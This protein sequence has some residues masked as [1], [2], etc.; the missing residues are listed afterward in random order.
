MKLTE[1]NEHR[2]RALFR[3]RDLLTAIILIAALLVTYNVWKNAIQIAN[4]ALQSNFAFRVKEVN[5]R[6]Q[7]RMAIY[8]QV[9]LATSGLFRAS[10]TVSREEFHI[11]IESLSIGKNYPG[12]QGV[13]FAAIVPPD[14]VDR[15]IDAVRKEGFPD[16]TISPE[17]PRDI[18]TAIVYLEPFAGRNLRAFGFD[19]YSDPTRRAAMT[20]ARDTGM[21]A[22]SGK[23]ILVQEGEQDIQFGF[24][25][26]QPIY[27][28]GTDSSS[29]EARRENLIGWVYSPF[30]MNDFMQGLNGHQEGDL[31]IEIYDESISDTSRMYD[32]TESVS[33]TSR[34]HRLKNVNQVLT[35]NRTWVVASTALPA[36]E[37]K[38]RSDRPQ[39]VMQAGFS[40]SLML[41]LLIWLFLDDRARAVQAANQAM[42]L[43]LYDTLTGL[44]NRKLLEERINQALANARRHQNCVA[45]LFIDLDKFKPVNDNYGHAYGDL[46]LR[47]VGRRLHDCMRESDTASRIGGDEFVALLSEVDGKTAASAVGTKILN[48]LNKPYDIAGHV[49]NISASIGAALYPEHASDGKALM[50]AADMAMYDAKNSGRGTVRLAQ[51]GVTHAA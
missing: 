49:F 11:F 36:F 7:Q 38:M 13:G 42:Q 16:Y 51:E 20:R 37:E 45:L 39:L 12:V 26:Y 35:G 44:P 24:L 43:A 14:E 32:S 21:L 27:R 18:Y 48:A 9:L 19:M 23:V 50:R 41:A 29:V 15:H 28:K 46:L 33:A 1:R 2:L 30:R 5:D 17:G 6:I 31:D 4:Q 8:E 10:R 25:I 47:E 22:T 40:M 3:T 34:N